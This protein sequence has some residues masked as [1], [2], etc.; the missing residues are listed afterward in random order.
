MSLNRLGELARCEGDE[1]RAEAFYH[2]S[3]AL[4]QQTG[5]KAFVASAL[6]NLGYIAQHRADMA[7]ATSHFSASLRLF[8]EIGDRKGVAECLM[9]LAGL[10]GAQGQS[11]RAARLFGAAETL[12]EAV[13]VTLW[14]ANRLEYQRNLAYLQQQ[15][16]PEIL[17]SLWAQGRAMTLEA[18]VGEALAK[19]HP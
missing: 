4:F 5:R 7:Q 12:R 1:S 9:G 14:P 16:E 11:E 3:L 18:A 10:A 8:Q 15:L 2:E 13:G 6:H 17:A 19:S